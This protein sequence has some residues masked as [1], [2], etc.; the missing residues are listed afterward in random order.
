MIWAKNKE[1]E[2]IKAKPK[3]EG[4]CPICES[5]LVPKC[6]VVKSWHWS[7]KSLTDCD[8]WSEPESEW[9]LNWK[10]YFEK[11]EQEVIMENH[12]ADVKTKNDLIIEFQNSPISP[13]DICDR[14]IFY[15]NMIWILNGES[16]GKGLNIKD[17]GN[18]FTLA[19]KNPPK[20]WFYSEKDI[21]IDMEKEVM[22]INDLIDDTYE[23]LDMVFDNLKDLIND[24]PQNFDFSEYEIEYKTFYGGEKEIKIAYDLWSNTSKE[25]NKLKIRRSMFNSRTIFYIKKLYKKVPCYGWGYLMYKKDFVKKFGGKNEKEESS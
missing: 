6:G 4:I 16:I 17:K 20:S 9:H 23:R 11:E 21:Y 10:D 7:H 25:L 19:W 24:N 12:I 15:G 8:S 22:E 1:G 18:Y 2:R 13:D 3:E 14:E 5:K